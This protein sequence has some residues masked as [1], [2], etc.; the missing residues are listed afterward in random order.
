MKP[1]VNPQQVEEYLESQLD[2]GFLR[3]VELQ[4]QPLTTKIKRQDDGKIMRVHLYH[5][6]DQRIIDLR[7]RLIERFCTADIPYITPHMTMALDFPTEDDGNYGASYRH[8][9]TI[10]D[11]SICLRIDEKEINKPLTAFTREKFKQL[12]DY[13]EQF[14][15]FFLVTDN[16]VE[17]SHSDFWS[18]FTDN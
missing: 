8:R 5:V 1:G 14:K 6:T 12:M 7:Q 15:P 2:N 18:T 16:G 11:G 10:E 9:F 17:C 3:Q 13:Q 4:D